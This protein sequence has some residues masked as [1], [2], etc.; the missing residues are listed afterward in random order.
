VESLAADEMVEVDFLP[1]AVLYASDDETLSYTR[2][3]KLLFLTQ[4]ETAVTPVYDFVPDSYGPVSEA[5]SRSVSELEDAGLVERSVSETPAGHERLRLRLTEDGRALIEAARDSPDHGRLAA[6]VDAAEAAT[7]EYD[8]PLPEL[9]A[10]L[11]E[12]YS[13]YDAGRPA[14]V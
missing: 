6:A 8:I 7:T 5:V 13:Q 3:Q 11:S 12:E 9:L 14:Q 2:L 10:R 4:E 1:L